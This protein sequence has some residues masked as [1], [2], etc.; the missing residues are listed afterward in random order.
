MQARLEG[1]RGLLLFYT[2]QVP[3][4]IHHIIRN[5]ILVQAQFAYSAFYAN[6]ST[7]APELTNLL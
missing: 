2:Y 1:A 6:F 4:I 5:R 3:G 7:T